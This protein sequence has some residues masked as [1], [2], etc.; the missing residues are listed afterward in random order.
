MISSHYFPEVLWGE[1]V[2]I[3]NMMISDTGFLS[4]F[5]KMGY[6]SVCGKFF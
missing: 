1:I 3:R 5:P 6:H 4:I 2:I